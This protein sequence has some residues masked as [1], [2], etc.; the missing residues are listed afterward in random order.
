MTTELFK[1]RN[2]S[3]RFDSTIT[4]IEVKAML[5]NPGND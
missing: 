3:R 5:R 1:E 4:D 2:D